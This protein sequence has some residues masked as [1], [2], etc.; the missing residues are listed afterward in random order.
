[1]LTGRGAAEAVAKID[2]LG[3]WGEEGERCER[4]RVCVCAYLFIRPTCSTPVHC[5]VN[6]S[7]VKPL[8]LITEAQLAQCVR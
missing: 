8:G 3:V 1:M 7:L 5:C 4:A 6:N 2:E